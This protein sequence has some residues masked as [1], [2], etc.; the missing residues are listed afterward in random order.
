MATGLDMM[1]PQAAR[2]WGCPWL[3]GGW[4]CQCGQSLLVG[5]TSVGET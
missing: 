2:L 4:E 3:A 1:L 5:D